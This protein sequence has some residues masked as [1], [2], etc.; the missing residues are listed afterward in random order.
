M[1]LFSRCFHRKSELTIIIIEKKKSKEKNDFKNWILRNTFS[2]FPLSFLANTSRCIT[3]PYKLEYLFFVYF[4]FF[5][6]FLHEEIES[7]DNTYLFYC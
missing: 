1:I 6:F 3:V 4:P 5:F 2:S 7:I